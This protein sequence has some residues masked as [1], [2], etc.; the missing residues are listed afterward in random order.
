[1]GAYPR[2][3]GG[4]AWHM[5]CRDY[6]EFAH[7]I[8][9][10]FIIHFH[11]F[12]ISFRFSI[13]HPTRRN[14]FLIAPITI[15]DP[16][17]NDIPTPHPISFPP[18]SVFI[19]LLQQPRECPSITAFVICCRFAKINPDVIAEKGH[20]QRKCQLS[21]CNIRSWLYGLD[22]MHMAASRAQPPV[23]STSP[24]CETPLCGAPQVMW[25]GCLQTPANQP[26]LL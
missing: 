23:R 3:P 20:R 21:I 24:E 16:V 15:C 2:K 6:P 4:V 14:P 17:T 26:Q 11:I 12:H 19:S 18:P 1:V 8:Y 22:I 9:P 13:F 10:T 7:S 5:A 25:C